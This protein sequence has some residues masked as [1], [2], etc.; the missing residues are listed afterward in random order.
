[1]LAYDNDKLL[2]GF[3]TYLKLDKTEKV[4]FN[5][6]FENYLKTQALKTT[7]SGLELETFSWYK[8]A[9][10]LIDTKTKEGLQ[11]I[12]D[13]DSNIKKLGQEIKKLRFA[14]K[15]ST[16]KLAELSGMSI[17]FINQLENGKASL[18]KAS[19]LTKLAK[20]FNINPDEL[21]YLAGYI[22]NKPIAEL[23]WKVNMRSNLSK[24]GIEGSYINEIIDY[25]ETVQIK[26]ERQKSLE[27]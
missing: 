2:K 10:G 14:Q 7:F 8:K 3:E 17:G 13:I 5:K 1:M 18:P 12:Y 27:N 4:S 23:D 6:D 16:H 21:L 20:I 11:E 9:L 22:N 15:W 19:N 24:I 25:I 26:Q